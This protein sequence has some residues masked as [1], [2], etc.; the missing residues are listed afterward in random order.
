MAKKKRIV[1]SKKELRE[2]LRGGKT[3]ESLILPWFSGIMTRL[4]SSSQEMSDNSA[5]A[6]QIQEANEKLPKLELVKPSPESFIN[7][8]IDKQKINSDFEVKQQKLSSEVWEVKKG[9]GE[10][11]IEKKDKKKRAVNFLVKKGGMSENQEVVDE[12]YDTFNDEKKLGKKL[13]EYEKLQKNTKWLSRV[14]GKETS[15]NSNAREKMDMVINKYVSDERETLKN[16]TEQWK[17]KTFEEVMGKGSSL[18]IFQKLWLRITHPI[19]YAKYAAVQ[20]KAKYLRFGKSAD[21]FADKAKTAL[22]EGREKVEYGKKMFDQTKEEQRKVMTHM[23]IVKLRNKEALRLERVNKKW[24]L[25]NKDLTTHIPKL[26]GPKYVNKYTNLAQETVGEINKLGDV[27]VDAVRKG[28]FPGIKM[29]MVGKAS[30][31]S[32]SVMTIKEALRSR[33]FGEFGAT[34]TKSSWLLSA[35]ELLPIIGSIQSARRIGDNSLGTSKGMQWAEFGI[36]LGL[37]A[38]TLLT[39]GTGTGVAMGV[40]ALLKGGTK[41]A[42]KVGT[43]ALAKK[44]GKEIIEEGAE[45]VIKKGGKKQATNVSNKLLAQS[46]SKSVGKM[47]QK[48]ATELLKTTL[49]KTSA[50]KGKDLWKFLPWKQAG[51]EGVTEGASWSWD[52]YGPKNKTI[53]QVAV[54]VGMKKILTKNQARVVNM[55]RGGMRKAA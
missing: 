8:S 51:Y 41:V 9:G 33:S 40:R 43:K 42:T 44:V 1:S 29:K 4:F 46:V 12:F 45:M 5:A 52:K 39:L 38:F 6:K 18:N 32:V 35:A 37:D 10:K 36:N 48:Q 53:A 28:K 55:V 23:K 49:R 3:S 16:G 19:E 20:K 30:V 31:I 17:M 15:G 24:N 34:V 11:R 13:D 47:T 25:K 22:D 26:G 7:E 14:F 27:G 54:N 2:T 50:K 21:R